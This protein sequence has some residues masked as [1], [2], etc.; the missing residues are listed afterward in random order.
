VPDNHL[1][2]SS[3]EPYSQVERNQSGHRG[4]T[5]SDLSA[6]AQSPACGLLAPGSSA[7]RASA[8][9]LRPCGRPVA[10][11]VVLRSVVGQRCRAPGLRWSLATCHGG[12]GCADGA[13]ATPSVG[14]WGSPLG[15]GRC[16]A[17]P[18]RA[19]AGGGSP[20][21]T[22][23]RVGARA[24][25]AAVRSGVCGA[26][27]PDGPCPSATRPPDTRSALARPGGADG[28]GGAVS[29]PPTGPG[30]LAPAGAPARCRSVPPLLG[31]RT[32]TRHRLRSDANTLRLARAV[33]PLLPTSH[34]AR[35]AGTPGPVRG[36]PCPRA[37]SRCLGGAPGRLGRAPRLAATSASGAAGHPHRDAPLTSAP[38]THGRWS[39]RTSGGPPPPPRQSVRL[40]VGWS[41]SPR[42]PG[43]HP[44]GGRQRDSAAKPAR[45]GLPGRGPRP[46]AGACLLR[47]VVP[48]GA[49]CRPLEA[50]R[51]V[52]RVWRG[53]VSAARAPQG[54][55]GARPGAVP[56]PGH[57]RAPPRGGLR[58]EVAPAL[59]QDVLVAPPVA[60]AAPRA[61]VPC[62][63]LGSSR[64]G[65]WHGRPIL[66]GR[67][68]L[69]G[70]A[71][72]AGPPLPR[73]HGAPGAEAS[74]RRCPPAG[75]PPP[76]RRGCPGTRP[77]GP[78]RASHV[79]RAALPASHALGGPRQTL[80][81]RTTAR[82]RWGLLGR[83]HHRRRHAP[84]SRGW[85]TLQRVRSL[86]RSPGGPGYASPVL[87]GCASFT[88]ATRGRSG[89]GDLTPQGLTPCKK[90]QASLGALTHRPTTETALALP[91]AQE[92]PNETLAAHG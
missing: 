88:E 4:R 15:G 12:V 29:W 50:E 67:A 8:S 70:P 2:G 73:V 16:A 43:L 1:A 33:C 75:P 80:G 23:G 46:V 81:P 31:W 3:S 79:P 45:R 28:T 78:V 58:A 36:T 13:P 55:G 44:G 92:S 54:R 9:R 14:L 62:G 63:L 21:P 17:G 59:L 27:A 37:G 56:R 39:P 83:S 40:G 38:S 66:P 77:P 26:L 76:G 47:R 41:V 82:P 71:P 87:F 65:G 6:P 72:S 35:R 60:G 11:W 69:P 53:T 42:P 34:R 85:S 18:G 84:R 74:A 89:W 24:G 91:L 86:W 48:V 64:P 25:V 52:G 10:S 20:C 49:A 22:R 57:G 19:T 7:I 61:L 51:G 68:M 5:A 32:R 30:R 90:R